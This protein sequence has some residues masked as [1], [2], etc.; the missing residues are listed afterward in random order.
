MFSNRYKDGTPEFDVMKVMNN[1]YATMKKAYTHKQRMEV[2]DEFKDMMTPMSKAKLKKELLSLYDFIPSMFEQWI[3]D[4]LTNKFYGGSYDR[5]INFMNEHVNDLKILHNEYLKVKGSSDGISREQYDE[6]LKREL[7]KLASLN[8]AK[9][10]NKK[11]MQNMLYSFLLVNQQTMTWDEIVKFYNRNR[12]NKVR[13]VILTRNMIDE[14][15]ER[16]SITHG[17][18]LSDAKLN[19]QQNDSINTNKWL[20]NTPW[21]SKIKLMDYGK[22]VGWS[23]EKIESA[24]DDI[25][26]DTFNMKEQKKLMR[27]HVYP[28]YTFVFDYFFPG[29]FMYL[30]AINV[31][32]RKAFFAIPDEVQKLGNGWVVPVNPKPTTISAINSLNQILSL[33]PVKG[34]IMDNEPAWTSGLFHDYCKSNDIKYRHEH[35]NKVGNLVQ[36]NEESR[37]NHS[38]T[39]LIDRLI[40]TLRTMN[41]NLGN[42]LS[43]E[44]ETMQFLINEYNRSPHSTLSRL[45]KRKVSPNDV[46]ASIYLENLVVSELMKENILTEMQD[47]YDVKGHVRVFNESSPMDKL[48]NKLLPGKWEVVGK[49]DGLI[50]LKQGNN[51]IMVN[52]WMIK[53]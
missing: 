10:Q 44:P 31:N 52:R 4:K 15:T 46:N 42:K 3:H 50:R 24:T 5:F 23:S 43:I 19:E 45:T 7:L 11:G 53:T 36:T 28:R 39:A 33:T 16:E 49:K 9:E 30:L 26:R 17:V 13:R 29:R 20:S 32:T 41:Y 2:V 34:I 25:G 12:A 40:R 21:K 8:D 1:I 47:G 22:R 51:E 35:K 14:N 6:L 38:T 27:H 48:K 37:G 18:K